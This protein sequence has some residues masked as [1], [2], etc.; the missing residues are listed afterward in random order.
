[1]GTDV[2]LVGCRR[3]ALEAAARLGLGV[4]VL[5][6]REP[7]EA[8]P[9]ARGWVRWRTVER[10]TDR[11]AVERAVG[12]LAQGAQGA[13]GAPGKRQG[14]IAAVV[15]CGEPGVLA[16]A[17]ARALLGLPGNDPATSERC[18][19]KPAM[20]RA[21]AAHDVRC[22]EWRPVDPG[23]RASELVADL[24]L[25]VVLKL[26]RSSGGRGMVTALDEA[27]VGRAL[28]AAALAERFVH[29]PE[30]SVES[31]VVDGRAVFVNLTDYLVRSHANVLPAELSPAERAAVLSLNERVLAAMGIERGMTHLE[32]FRAA[33]GLVFGEIAVRPPGGRI[34]QLLRRAWGFD[35][36][37]ALLAIELGRPVRFPA[38]PRCSAGSWMLHPGEGDVLAVEGLERAR[39]VAGVRR[40]RVRLAPGDH[41]DVRLG[42]GQDVGHLEASGPDAASVARALRAAHAAV[43]IRMRRA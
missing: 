29:G 15:A 8:L 18:C 38:G 12:E 26:A 11:A 39:A 16:A 22:A 42:L 28:P 7:A 43:R 40:V 41:V 19:D 37:E 20:K 34:V 31:F 6:E 27:Q 10:L 23:T 21:A 25:P 24:G 13:Q 5:H 2:L 14:G 30:M 33:D 3:G 32:L 4:H 17:W 35:P 1:M 36:W 9:G